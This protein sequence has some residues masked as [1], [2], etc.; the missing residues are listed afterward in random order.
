M[1]RPLA[2]TVVKKRIF[3]LLSLHGKDKFT[4]RVRIQGY[5]SSYCKGDYMQVF[6]HCNKVTGAA[7]LDVQCRPT[8]GYLNLA[9][10]LWELK[11]SPIHFLLRCSHHA[12]N[13]TRVQSLTY[14]PTIINS[15]I[16]SRFINFKFCLFVK[17]VKR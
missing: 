15:S 7:G 10:V 11:V 6:R 1:L 3:S 8:L 12:I 4:W 9:E 16:K 14:S 17:S 5:G 13:L 2:Q